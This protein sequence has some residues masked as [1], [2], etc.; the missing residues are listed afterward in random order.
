M[1]S[2]LLSFAIWAVL[3]GS[4]ASAEVTEEQLRNQQR[5]VSIGFVSAVLTLLGEKST[6]KHE[7]FHGC[8]QLRNPWQSH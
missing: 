5:T 3:L 7:K 2:H 1:A 4:V 6:K 8:Q